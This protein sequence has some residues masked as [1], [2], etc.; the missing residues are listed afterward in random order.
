MSYRLNVLTAFSLVVPGL[1]SPLS[2]NA[3]NPPGKNIEM[4]FHYGSIVPHHDFM[5][6]FMEGP[7]MAGEVKIGFQTHGK[8]AWEQLY[9]YPRYGFGYY[10]GTIGNP[11]ILGLPNAVYSF[12]DV[13]LIKKNRFSFNTQMALGVSYN[14]HIYDPATNPLNLAIGCN[15]NVFFY[16]NL[17][18]GFRLSD[19]I[20][21]K[22]AANFTHFSNGAVKMPNT[23]FYM[24]DYYAALQYDLDDHL[25]NPYRHEL[26]AIEKRNQ[27]FFL[28]ASGAKQVYYQQD[29]YL[30]ATLSAGY[31]RL[32]GRI[33]KVGGGVDL[34]YDASLERN[35]PGGLPFGWLIR[36]GFF[37][38]H[39]LLI[40]RFSLVV[41]Q[42]FYG[43]RK[44]NLHQKYYSRLGIKYQ[45]MNGLFLNISLKSHWGKADFIEWGFGYLLK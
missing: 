40:H 17:N 20:T 15:P 19:R 29:H 26:P 37:A 7:L 22:Q 39:E 24:L 34:F 2:L 41:Q 10:F 31:Y 8:L 30:M 38:A 4:V 25:P 33:N 12:F 44:M 27:M 21:L 14:F 28:I 43:Y 36:Q 45:L 23:G 13:P 35:E 5:H 1:I 16:F 9:N 11:D 6:D 18:A 42:G 3:G 32:I